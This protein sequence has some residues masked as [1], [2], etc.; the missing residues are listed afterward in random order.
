MKVCEFCHHEMGEHTPFCEKG[1]NQGTPCG[2]RAHV[3]CKACG[4]PISGT[5]T[6]NG[7]YY[8]HP[9]HGV[10][11]YHL[12]TAWGWTPSE[13]RAAMECEH[14]AVFSQDSNP[15]ILTCMVCHSRLSD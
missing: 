4:R 14:P 6:I 15:P 5:A 11:C 7:Q 12:T 2:C 10:D 8:C 9:D 1:M 13:I 3:F